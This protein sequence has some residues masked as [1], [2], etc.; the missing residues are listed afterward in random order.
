MEWLYGMSELAEA[1]A[2]LGDT[3]AAAA[4]YRLLLPWAALNAA[5]PV[6]GIR[7][8][9]SRYLGILA[10]TTKHWKQAERHFEDAAAM[11][12]GMGA[13]PWVAHTQH[14]YA[15]M[16]LARDETSDRERALE[17]IAEAVTTYRELGM[18]SWAKAASGLERALQADSAP[19]R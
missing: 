17:L 11:N 15:R 1:S 7:G 13:R 4:L 10:T 2:L 5:D 12:E 19:P 16:L 6:E 18:K 9:V 8:S 14:D 3:A